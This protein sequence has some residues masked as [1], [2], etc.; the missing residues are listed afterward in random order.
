MGVDPGSRATGYGVVRAVGTGFQH[1]DHGVIRL[2]QGELPQRLLEIHEQ[3]SDVITQHS[4]AAAAVED[5]FQFK[6]ARSALVLGHARGAAI[7]AAASR[8][9][10]VF[11]Y[12]PSEM[13]QSV[14]GSGRAEK[15]QVGEMVRILL[16][17]DEVPAEDAAD[18]LGM[19]ICHAMRGP[20]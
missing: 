7:L 4:P 6:N 16:S 10:Q 5:L 14:T 18:A 11:S 3:L 8:G 12:T 9:V 1:I 17:L 19:A 15:R 2:A 20:R 13:K